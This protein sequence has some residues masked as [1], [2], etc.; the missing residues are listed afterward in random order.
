[1]PSAP[2]EADK[3]LRR[4][5]TPSRLPRPS[6]KELR[7]ACQLNLALCLLKLNKPVEAEAQCTDVLRTDKKS[8]KAYFRRRGLFLRRS[9]L[10]AL[11]GVQA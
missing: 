1:M 10:Q 8:L 3:A 11:C 2:P 7:T 6:G 4:Q 9:P 5:K